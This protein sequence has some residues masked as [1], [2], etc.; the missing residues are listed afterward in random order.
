LDQLLVHQH[1]EVGEI[2]A[3]ASEEPEQVGLGG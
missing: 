1:G 3:V 2:G